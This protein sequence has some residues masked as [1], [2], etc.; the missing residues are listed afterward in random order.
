[1]LGEVRVVRSLWRGMG[2]LEEDRE[3]FWAGE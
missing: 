3:S 2:R 1:M